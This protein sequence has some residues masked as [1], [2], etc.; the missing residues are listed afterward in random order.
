MEVV[1]ALVTAKAAAAETKE[2]A[3]RVAAIGAMAT[4]FAAAISGTAAYSSAQAKA[5]VTPPPPSTGSSILPGNAAASH[6]S[7]VAGGTAAIENIPFDASQVISSFAG[8][9]CLLSTSGQFPYCVDTTVAAC[10]KDVEAAGGPFAGHHHCVARPG[11]I[12][13]AAYRSKGSVRPI[14]YASQSQC[15]GDRL[16]YRGVPGIDAIS[17][18]CREISLPEN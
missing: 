12:Y 9:S 17:D 15:D 10:G 5:Q 13:C 4:V 16:S 8:R 14:C 18:S 6:P 7:T 1:Q 2:S 3:T 11:V